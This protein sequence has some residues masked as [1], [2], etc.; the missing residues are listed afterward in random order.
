MPISCHFRDGKA[1]LVT[2]SHVSSAIAST[3]PLP[4]PFTFYDVSM[5]EQLMS[6][7]DDPS[8]GIRLMNV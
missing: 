8:S 7:V 1:L 2:S 3:R 6:F 5:A 4:L